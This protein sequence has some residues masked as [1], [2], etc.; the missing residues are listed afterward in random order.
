MDTSKIIKIFQPEFKSHASAILECI[1]NFENI[2]STIFKGNRN[3]IK[4]FQLDQ[5]EINIK[6]FKSPNAFNSLIYQYVRPSKAKRSFE[7]AL[8]LSDLGISTPQ[9]IAY[10]EY[11]SIS[12][13]KSSY[14][15]SKHITYD[16]DFRVLIH[17]PD[18]PNRENILRAFTEFTFQLHENNIN[19]LDH[20]PG[21]TLI[22]KKGRGYEFYLIDLNR[23]RFENMSFK[24][25]MYNFRRLWLS[26]TMVKIMAETY[27][28]LFHKSYQETYLLMA[29]YSQAFQK[30][31][32]AKKMRRIGRNPTFKKYF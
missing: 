23:M 19:F 27:A 18:Y 6:S 13:L 28:H 4:S 5:L 2:G 29:K 14:Y 22:E 16:L 10:V 7:Y 20:S 21:N 26:K 12:G 25:R 17:K 11:Y 15:I 8:K 3:S 1:E 30:R 24:K 32:N 9:P 31:M